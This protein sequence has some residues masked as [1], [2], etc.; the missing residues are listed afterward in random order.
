MSEISVK[1]VNDVFENE[2]KDIVIPS[3]FPKLINDHKL[4]LLRYIVRVI[5]IIALCFDFDV[6]SKKEIYV[7]QFKQNNYQ[8]IKWLIRYLLPFMNED[9]VSDL[10]SLD[11]IYTKKVK[12]VDITLSSP[13]YV[14]SNIQYNRCNRDN[15][16]YTE[17][18][19]QVSDLD[20]NFYLLLGTIKMMSHKM[21]V[22]WID[23][24]PYTIPYIESDLYLTTE[25]KFQNKKLADWDPCV[26]A[27]L[28]L[29]E[30]KVFKD[31]M[32]IQSDVSLI[33]M[34]SGL[35]VGDI[36]NTI[37]YDFYYA[38]KGIKWTIY[39][40][41]VNYRVKSLPIIV[42]LSKI[43]KNFDKCMKNVEW[44]SLKN[45]D[46][47]IFSETWKDLIEKAENNK[48]LNIG[49]IEFSNHALTMILKGII[50][51][52]E[53]GSFALDSADEENTYIPIPKHNDDEGE[54]DEDEDTDITFSNILPS[55]KSINP[56]FMYMYF[57]ESIEALKN[58]WYGSTLMDTNML[59]FNEYK[60]FDISES[61]NVTHKNIY[62]Y[63]KCMLYHYVL[64]KN[65]NKI[66][67]KNTKFFVTD[68][69]PAN[70][71]GLEKYQ[72]DEIL[73]R[74]N[75][76]YEG[77]D[78][79]YSWFRI[80]NYIINLYKIDRNDFGE[81][82]RINYIIYNLIRRKLIRI[83]Y[84]NLI[85]KGV[86]TKFIPAPEKTNLNIVQRDGIKDLEIQKKIF[87]KSN[88]NKYYT[89]SF[90]YL[91]RMTYRSSEENGISNYF[92]ILNNAD[93]KPWYAMYSYDWI[94]QIGFCHHFINNRIIFI[95]G[96]TGVGKSVEVPKLFLYY[97][98]ALD[99]N[100]DAK[101][102]CAEPRQNPTQ[103]NAIQVAKTCGLPIFIEKETEKEKE[104]IETTN[105]YIQYDHKEGH[106]SKNVRYASL[107]YMTGDTLLP[108][109]NNP[110]LKKQRIDKKTGKAIYSQKN[111]YD[112]IMIDETHEHKKYM[113][114]LLST[115]KNSLELNNSVRLVIISATMNDDEMTYRRFYRDIND[116]MKSP[117]NYW[118]KQHNLDRI[119][120][121][122]RLHISPPGIGTNFKIDEYYEPTK[123]VV[124]KAKE[125]IKNYPEN[126][127]ILIFH[128]GVGEITKTVTALNSSSDIP[129]NT[130]A[131]PFHSQVDKGLAKI[132]SDNDKMIPIKDFGIIPVISQITID[133]RKIMLPKGNNY[134]DRDNK[135]YNR[136][137]IVATNIAE[138]S[139]TIPNLRYVID[140]G[141]QK[142]DMYDFRKR[143][144]I[145]RQSGISES[146]RVQRKGRVGRRYDGTVFYLYEKNSMINNKTEYEI[147]TSN[148]FLELFGMLKTTN[149]E[150][151]FISDDLNPNIRTNKKDNYYDKLNE[152]LE[153]KTNKLTDIIKTQYFNSRKYYNY[154]G[155]NNSYDYNNYKKCAPYY[156][157]GYDEN[158]LFDNTGNFY[159][160][161]PEELSL[162]RN[163]AGD[164]IDVVNNSDGVK[165]IE[166]NKFKATISS[167]K[168]KSFWYTL[169]DYLYIVPTIEKNRFNKTTLGINF[170][171]YQRKF[172]LDDFSHGAFRSLMFGIAFGHGADIIQMLCLN[173]VTSYDI[174]TLFYKE[175]NNKEKITIL[176]K[177][178]KFW[179]T[180]KNSDLHVIFD[181]LNDLYN[182]IIKSRNISHNKHSKI[183][184][185]Y[186][187]NNN[188]ISNNMLKDFAN[189][190]NLTIDECFDLLSPHDNDTKKKFIRHEYTKL[191]KYIINLLCQIYTQNILDESETDMIREWCVLHD[192]DLDV[193]RKY[194]QE[195]I[196][197]ISNLNTHMTPEFETFIKGLTSRISRFHHI[198]V[199]DNI[200]K[201]DVIHLLSYPYNICKKMEDTTYCLHLYYPN[202]KYSVEIENILQ[203]KHSP[204]TTTKNIS[205]YIFFIKYDVENDKIGYIS[206]LNANTISVLSH[207]YYDKYFQ[208]I[209]KIINDTI[210]Y[211]KSAVN[212]DIKIFGDKKIINK[213]STNISNA[214]TNYTG[215]IN[216]IH[217]DFSQIKNSRKYREFIIAIEP[218]MKQYIDTL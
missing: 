167:E 78:G 206:P 197:F 66:P 152:N 180:N 186:I 142:T 70:W 174:K 26:H 164:I 160:V 165:I 92:D 15:N 153:Y 189:K 76:K 72:Q 85:F 2:I 158:S 39:D 53:R 161:H 30:D 24:L 68:M 95:T 93:G 205:G 182:M 112:I 44:T 120:V 184:T 36:Y 124:T 96:S 101:L 98:K 6:I 133:R 54:D 202:I 125:I 119:N 211:S 89:S 16:T 7:S 210:I 27:S 151:Q 48:K 75:D 159:I 97:A 79:C 217:N 177:M 35:Q 144:N 148:L 103:S 12:N 111:I 168:M 194:I 187:K 150:Q 42:A 38:I 104:Y 178:S 113:D 163:I 60:Y 162:I 110:I 192:I 87:E 77:E 207:I 172:Q 80:P 179:E 191:Q 166:K 52:F 69:Y 188:I 155:N 45:L 170:L 81:I 129:E 175:L 73:N 218:Q 173:K 100:N 37:T 146:S 116:N 67:I 99:Y 199:D 13:S 132:I 176:A 51:S 117:L 83:V 198:F 56:K 82:K 126:G 65:G 18:Q 171:D 57:C 181:M 34:N 91:T 21:H 190:N 154:F 8:D 108:K 43:F 59:K 115:L 216:L 55:L 212:Q 71:Y 32:E 169:I 135:Q 118:I 28:N 131:I 23:I 203:Y 10:V 29:S 31:N 114:L 215:T 49:D 50:F 106:H 22:N 123:D 102:V 137:I 196:S 214:I 86:L 128:S 14:H 157:T 94:A 4:L 183:F 107:A 105:Y 47:K 156:S 74:L 130:I 136:L 139:I 64:D 121:D 209:M 208:H 40:I 140:T 143:G 25:S 200:D 147:S 5:N 138:A 195:Y 46:R 149:T 41:S 201:Y 185:P 63:A 58:T 122:R 11:E 141:S 90:N 1:L 62:N 127:H 204:N 61:T 9:T 20:H 84:G 134:S 3:V 193:I 33:Q 109:L 88:N 213:N 17:R 19:F 145:L